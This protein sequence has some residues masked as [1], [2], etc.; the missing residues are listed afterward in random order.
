MPGELFLSDGTAIPPKA[1][2][3]LEPGMSVTLRLPGGGGYGQ[4][5]ERDPQRVA[6][7]VRQDRVSPEAAHEDYGINI[8][9]GGR[10]SRISTEDEETG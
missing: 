9:I 4:A 7:D 3:N 1:T 6:E 5:H 8:T 2:Y 10:P